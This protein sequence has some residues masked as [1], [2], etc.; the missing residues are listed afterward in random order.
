MTYGRTAVVGT[1]V[2]GL[3]EV[4]TDGESGY[5]V[6]VGEVRAMAVAAI[7]L[8]SDTEKHGRFADAARARAQ[9]EFDSKKIIPQ[10]EALYERLL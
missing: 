9:S 6:P 4:V 2:G 3:P 10:Y 7:G 8:L 1:A 5:L